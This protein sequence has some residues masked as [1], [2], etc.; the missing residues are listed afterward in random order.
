MTGSEGVAIADVMK[1]YA[2]IRPQVA[3]AALVYL[4]ER[5]SID[6]IFTLDH[7]RFFGLPLGAQ[8]SISHFA[9]VVMAGGARELPSFARLDRWDTCPY[10]VHGD[11]AA[12]SYFGGGSLHTIVTSRATAIPSDTSTKR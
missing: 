1:K 10:V 5:D 2:D 11:S 6:T 3:D 12:S 9:R 7:R 4:A 8:A